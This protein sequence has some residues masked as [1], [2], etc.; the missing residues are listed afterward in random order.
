MNF[1]SRTPAVRTQAI[2]TKPKP[3]AVEAPPPAPIKKGLFGSKTKAAPPKVAEPEPVKKGGL[4]GG[5]GAAKP[6]AKAAPAPAP[7]SKKSASFMSQAVRALDFQEESKSARDQRLL[8]EARAGKF[9]GRNGQLSAE[10]AAILRRQITGTKKG[11]FKEWVE[12]EGEF[13]EKGYVAKGGKATSSTSSGAL[14]IGGI[15]LGLV[16]VSLGAVLSL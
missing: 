4:F 8:D 5:L 16:V 9:K 6:K 12:V 2:F 3:K 11:F 7:A 15:V 1:T 14:I 13:T 10:Q